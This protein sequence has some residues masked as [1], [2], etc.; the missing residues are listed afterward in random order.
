MAIVE[1]GLLTEYQ[2]ERNDELHT[3]GSVFKGRINNLSPSLQAAFIDIGLEKNAFSHYKD[4]VYYKTLL[5]NDKNQAMVTAHYDQL[6]EDIDMDGE[7]ETEDELENKPKPERRRNENRNRSGNDNRRNSDR[8]PRQKREERDGSENNRPKPRRNNNNDSRD[9]NRKSGNNRSRENRD[10]RD[11]RPKRDQQQNRSNQPKTEEK[12]GFWQWLLSLLGVK[13]AD[14]QPTEEKSN[15][16]RQKNNRSKDGERNKNRSNNSGSG[17]NSSSKSQNNGNNNRRPQRRRRP[18]NQQRSTLPQIKPEEIP[19]LLPEGAE[20][21]VQ[22]EKGPIGTKG[23]KVTTKVE[24]PG[25]YLVLLPNS[26]TRGVSKRIE[27]REERQR[28]QQIMKE[29]VLPEN[30]GC[31]CRTAGMGKKA[32]YFEMDVAMLLEQWDDMKKAMAKPAP[33]CIYR[34]PSLLDRSLREFLT[35]DIDEIVVDSE[36]AYEHV[37]RMVHR[38]SR[39]ERGKIRLYK[40]SEPIF[41]H[42]NLRQQVEN[43]FSRQVT[44]PSGGYICIDET[45]ALIAIDINSGR[46]TKGKDHPETILN[47]NLEAAEEIARQ[48]RLRNIGGLVVI[49]FIDM[50]SRKDQQ[51]IYKAMQ[52]ALNKDRARTKITPISRFGLMEMTRQRE[53]ESLQDAVFDPCPYCHGK[54]RIKSSTTVSV[55]IQRRLRALTKKRQ[56]PLS[57]RVICHPNVMTRLRDD[58]PD[59]LSSIER[60]LGGQLSFRSDNSLHIEEVRIIDQKTGRPLR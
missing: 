31:I 21:I 35:S 27:D 60:K 32:R 36:Q 28:L 15:Q 51:A 40:G 26:R 23:A 41:Q 17:Q 8:E 42:Y 9:N 56:H 25:H 39:E 55:E 33:V 48:V 7:F 43:I 53:H 52:D 20:V 34:E 58:D 37:M 14:S 54:G 44:L 38:L 45:E 47:T 12:K 46:S 29:L 5:T 50:R 11:N 6:R 2:I 18:T 57:V 24:I 16:N 13:S 3:V 22:V 49:D 30:M 4:L 19:E 59:F 1:D 10:G